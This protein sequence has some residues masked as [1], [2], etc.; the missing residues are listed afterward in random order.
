MLQTPD[1]L[2]RP[3]WELPSISEDERAT[4]KSGIYLISL[5]LAL[6]QSRR[7]TRR[8]LEITDAFSLMLRPGGSLPTAAA[9]VKSAMSASTS[10]QANLM[11][12]DGP[13]VLGS[14]HMSAKVI[15]SW[16]RSRPRTLRRLSRG[17]W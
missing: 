1:A 7:D 9:R 13:G 2:G 6:A 11:Y 10:S 5:T 8:S 17:R 4:H 12:P 3:V 16:T 15:I 14:K